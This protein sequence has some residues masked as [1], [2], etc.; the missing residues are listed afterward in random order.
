MKSIGIKKTKALFIAFVTVLSA[1]IIALGTAIFVYSSERSKSVADGGGIVTVHVYD[2]TEE[3]STLAGW[4]WIKGA[5]GTGYTM[6]ASPKAGEQFSKSYTVDGQE[7]TNTAHYIDVSFNDAEV[8]ALKDGTN[9]GLL[10]CKPKGSGADFWDKYQSE[11]SDVFV[12]LS[13]AFDDSNHADVYYIRKDKVAYTSLEEGKM[14]LEKV[15]G[16]RFTAVGASSVTVSFE[17]TSPITNTTDVSLYREGEEAPMQ[18]VKATPNAANSFAGTAVFTALKTSNFDYTVDYTMKVGDIP[19]GASIAKTALIDNREFIQ[20]FENAATQNT[21]DF[22]A[23]WTK[24]STTFKLWAPFASSVS[25]KLYNSSAGGDAASAP[26]QKFIPEGGA[27]GGI[28]SLTMSGDYKNKYYTYEVNNYGSIVEA[29]DPYAKACGVNGAR[30]MIVDLDD[31][32]P[33]GWEN[34]KHLYAMG[35]IAG[36]SFT[37]AQNADNPIVWEIHVKDFSSSPDSGMK[38]KGKFLAFTETGTTVPGL[39]GVK[40]GVDYLKELGITY[41]HL[42]PVYDF[43]TVDETASIDAGT[44]TTAD[45]TK[46][47]FNWGYDPLNYNIPEGSYATD[48][49]DGRVRINE[50]KQMVMALHKAGIGVV[51]DV[52]Y[53][54]TYATSGQALNDTVPGYYH[55]TN[56]VGDF[57]NDSGCGNATASERTMMRKYMVDSILYWATEYHIDGFRFDLMGIHDKVTMEKIRTKLDA[58]DGGNG[59]KILMYGEPWS[60]DGTYVPASYTKRVNATKTNISGVGEYTSNA[61]NDFIKHMYSDG[62]SSTCYVPRKDA[63]GNVVKDSNNKDIYDEITVQPLS[64][65]KERIAVFGDSG[66]DGLRGN[67]DPGQGWGNGAANGENTRK[68]MKMMEGGCGS[69]GQGLTVK[70]GGQLVA[71]ASAHDNYPLWDQIMGKQAGKETPLYYSNYIKDNA[72]KSELIAA[73]YL[74]SSAIPFM[75]AGEEMGRTKFGNHNSYNSPEK[76]NQIVWARQVEFKP[77]VDKYKAL[78]KL[79]RDFGGKLFSYSA[80]SNSSTGASYCYGNFTGSN[81]DGGVIAFTRTKNGATLTVSL[82]PNS[83][84]GSVKIGTQTVT[85]N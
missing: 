79:R 51:M 19:T 54:H 50:F 31:T 83:G 14:A 68:V 24:E 37:G 17:A 60:A 6:S 41:V 2:A 28:W 67:N 65:L 39:P 52:V 75:L 16:A 57:T 27:W 35:A 84:A 47:S 61:N 33:E 70:N 85:I 30:A 49:Y 66:R 58:L 69:S 22:G 74:S 3:Y 18:T 8:K 80:M 82:D 42:N 63:N 21:N 71:Y 7:K 78:I 55:R 23:T 59:K 32:D 76:G 48:A 56:E 29:M 44:I 15:T 10:I 43:A 81:E 40:T 64:S 45:N 11:T 72:V 20:T 53:N 25:V 46:D 12:D 38:Y 73:A 5:S 4:F 34:D 36:T 1:A 62:G 13:A 77:M 26:M 9:M